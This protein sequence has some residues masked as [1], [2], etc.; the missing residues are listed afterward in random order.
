MSFFVWLLLL[1]L[2]FHLS[3]AFQTLHVPPLD[4]QRLPH[5]FRE[6]DVAVVAPVSLC[7]HRRFIALLP[8][9]HRNGDGEQKQPSR[10][11]FVI[12]CVAN[13][14]VD[15]VQQPYQPTTIW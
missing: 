7:M 5:G 6:A 15:T 1:L 2:L 8:L 11:H 12:D 13:N 3:L 4:L 14:T 10:L 9:S